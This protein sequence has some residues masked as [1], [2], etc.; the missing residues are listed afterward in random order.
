MEAILS[1]LGA[2]LGPP[3]SL[4]RVS[5]GPVW[6]L[7]AALGGLLGASRGL[8]GGVLGPKARKVRSVLVSRGTILGAS[9]AVLEA[10]L[11]AFLGPSCC[12]L[13][14]LLGSSWGPLAPFGRPL[15]AF[16]GPVGGLL[17]R[18][19]ALL[20]LLG[21]FGA[22]LGPRGQSS[23]LL[24]AKQRIY[25]KIYVFRKDLGDFCLFGPSWGSS[26]SPF[27]GCSGT[28]ATFGGCWRVQ[29]GG[30]IRRSE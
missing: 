21:R 20:G 15:G 23:R 28:V 6:G 3:G 18:L 10:P 8:L 14:R 1:I 11:A 4:L 19:A 12:H 13:G 2:V 25:L 27:G 26:W 29:R 30:V 22:I 9:C 16:E 24:R 17:G 7:L 5:L